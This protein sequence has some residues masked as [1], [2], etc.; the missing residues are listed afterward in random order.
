[1]KERTRIQHIF[2][3]ALDQKLTV[4]IFDGPEADSDSIVTKSSSSSFF[5]GLVNAIAC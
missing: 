1:M 2:Y 5:H 3:A 4:E